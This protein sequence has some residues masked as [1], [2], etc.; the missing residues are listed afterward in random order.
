MAGSVRHPFVCEIPDDDAGPNA[1]SVQVSDWNDVHV[2]DEAGV[3][4]AADVGQV[5]VLLASELKAFVLAALGLSDWV[6]TTDS[7]GNPVT[8]LT[9]VSDGKTGV[10]GP[11]Q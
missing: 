1:G 3:L 2:Q 6:E 7:D 10:I 8:L 4:G 11:F 5:G 9:R